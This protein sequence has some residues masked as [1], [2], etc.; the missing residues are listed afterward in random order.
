M[1]GRQD[2][3]RFVLDIILMFVLMLVMPW[4]AAMLITVFAPAIVQLAIEVR[5]EY[6]LRRRPMAVLLNYWKD[7]E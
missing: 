5:R 3:I 6:L 7:I 2:L 4:W 1:N